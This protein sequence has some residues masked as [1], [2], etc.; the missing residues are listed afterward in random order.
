MSK[1]TDKSVKK[2]TKKHMKTSTKNRAIVITV[3][4]IL[5]LAVFAYFANMSGLAAKILPGAKIVQTIDGKEKTLDRVSIVE[6]N[7]YYS[8]AYSQLSSLIS[9]ENGVKEVYNPETGETYEDLIWENAA[10]LAQTQYMLYQKA[11][12]AGFKAE[13]ADK[14]ADAQVEALRDNVEYYNLLRSSNMTADQYLQSMYGKGMTVHIFRDIVRREAVVTEYQ[15]YLQQTQFMADDAAVQAKYD[16]DPVKYQLCQYQVYFVQAQIGENATEEE[17]QAA[18]DEA[19]KTAHSLC[20]GCKN[21]VEFRTRV[22]QVCADEYRERMA[23]GED[24]TTM[25]GI[26]KEAAK[27]MSEEFAEMCFNPETAEF[28]SMAFLDTQKTGAYAT[29][30][31]KVYLDDELTSSYRSIMFTDDVLSNISLSLEEKAGSHAKFHAKAEELMAQVTSEESFIDLVKQYTDDADTVLAG[32]Y[33][34]GVKESG[35]NKV[36]TADNPEPTLP[37]EDQKLLA[38]L[39]DPARKKGD[40][41]IIDCVASVQLYYFCGCEEA[42]RDSIRMDITSDNYQNWYNGAVTDNTYSTIVNHGLI[43]FFS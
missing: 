30:F 27:N 24:P 39:Q 14:F 41:Y 22:A 20:D 13:G 35:F 25:K 10:N 34:S 15:T 17:K 29:L 3:V 18:L 36:T 32:G 5:L 37:E 7:Y 11:K 1:G 28:T 12:E 40:M 43:D 21:A 2:K 23:N 26:S 16:A 4:I 42:W 19:L 8:K 38:W 9:G 6:M 33:V 31:E